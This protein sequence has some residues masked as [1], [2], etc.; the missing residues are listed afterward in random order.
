MLYQVKKYKNVLI[1]KVNNVRFNIYSNKK[2]NK[3]QMLKQVRY[4]F[5]NKDFIYP[6][7]GNNIN[8]IV[9]D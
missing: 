1:D 5:V 9:E 8:I 7:A 3:A 2:L 4:Y 6:E